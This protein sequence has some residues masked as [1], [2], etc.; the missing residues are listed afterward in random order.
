MAD[1][2]RLT[3]RANRHSEAC[4]GRQPDCD[5]RPVETVGRQD[6]RLLASG[7]SLTT[8]KVI[9]FDEPLEA[10]LERLGRTLICPR[11][12]TSVATAKLPTDRLT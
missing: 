10:A 8:P 5:R 11:R 7:W 3:R 6:G 2:V 9:S 12:K 1:R 4:C